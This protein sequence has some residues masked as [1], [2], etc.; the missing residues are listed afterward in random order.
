MFYKK[1]KKKLNVQFF[2][3]DNYPIVFATLLSMAL[4][5][6]DEDSQIFSAEQFHSHPVCIAVF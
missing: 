2:R 6:I 1:K 3:C 4:K 5:I